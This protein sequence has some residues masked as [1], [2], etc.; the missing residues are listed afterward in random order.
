MR[1]KKWNALRYGLSASSLLAITRTFCELQLYTKDE[2]EPIPVQA[3]IQ[4]F[5]NNLVRRLAL[6]APL[7]IV[8][9]FFGVL[10]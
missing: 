10:R 8:A 5:Y 6:Q 4:Y 2:P 1:G 9:R 3:S 7:C